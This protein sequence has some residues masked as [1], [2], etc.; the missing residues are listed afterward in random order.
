MP[1][2][3][4]IFLMNYRSK[5]Q[6]F[7]VQTTNLTALNVINREQ[8]YTTHKITYNSFTGAE[9]LDELS[10]FMRGTF[11]DFPHVDKIRELESQTIFPNINSVWNDEMFLN[12]IKEI[13]DKGWVDYDS[14]TY[15]SVSIYIYHNNGEFNFSFEEGNDSIFH[16]YA[17]S[18]MLA[19][20]GLE[21]NSIIN[22]VELDKETMSNAEFNMNGACHDAS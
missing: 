11:I 7:I 14:S 12:L 22:Q 18:D 5:R 8:F 6:F 13:D 1:S 9:M 19:N 10:E 16:G 15:D 3:E 17:L 21:Y 20:I 2:F 4:G